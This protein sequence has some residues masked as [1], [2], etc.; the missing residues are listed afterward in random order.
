MEYNFAA[1]RDLIQ[2]GLTKEEFDDLVYY[3]FHSVYNQF[4]DG[5]VKSSQ[6]RV[7]LVA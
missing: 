1:I 3:H 5:M 4:T 7:L 6:I 2:N